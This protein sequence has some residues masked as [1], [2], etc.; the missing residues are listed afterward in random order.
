MDSMNAYLALVALP[1][2]TPQPFYC[3]SENTGL[4]E[5]SLRQPVS[6]DFISV[7]RQLCSKRIDLLLKIRRSVTQDDRRGSYA[8]RTSR[9]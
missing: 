6:S 4:I 5:S 2:L 9:H 8:A 1:R 3:R 7:A